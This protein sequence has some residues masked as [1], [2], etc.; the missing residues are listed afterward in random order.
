MRPRVIGA[1]LAA[2]VAMT[3]WAAAQEKRIEIDA[4]IALLSDYIERGVSQSD[5]DPAI[6]GGVILT[7]KSGFYGGLGVSSLNDVLGNDAEL[8]GYA[9]YGTQ[10]GAYFVDVSVGYTGLFGNGN[11]SGFFEV[12]GVVNRDFGLANLTGG[13]SFAPGGR[14]L[15]GTDN[16]F[17]GYLDADIPV[18]TVPWLSIA[19]HGGYETGDGQRDRWDWSM[20]LAAYWKDIEFGVTYHDTNSGAPNADARAVFSIRLFF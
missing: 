14:R 3:G 1:A 11:S 15:P 9:G 6:Q 20:G 16:T 8:E 4:D 17:Y 18:P 10:L 2:L 12:S 19:L 7:D 13:L 5:E